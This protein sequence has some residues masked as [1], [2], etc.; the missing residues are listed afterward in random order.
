VT[1][2]YTGQ[3]HL[4]TDNAPPFWCVCW[5]ATEPA[6]SGRKLTPEIKAYV[7]ARWPDLVKEGLYGIGKRLNMHLFSPD[8]FASR[9]S[10]LIR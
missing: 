7:R 6:E 5:K 1:S 10:S 3:L 8:P 2:T 9:I 4:R